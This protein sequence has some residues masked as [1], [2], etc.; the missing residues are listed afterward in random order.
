MFRNISE[1]TLKKSLRSYAPEPSA[2]WQ[3]ETLARLRT[4]AQ[5][6]EVE[7]KSEV[8]AWSWRTRFIFWGGLLR[9]A[10]VPVLTVL[11]AVGVILP[12][13]QTADLPEYARHVE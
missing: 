11:I 1:S 2:L 5:T 8:I 6:E 9:R 12:N 13:W 10:F 4:L 3:K 7:Y